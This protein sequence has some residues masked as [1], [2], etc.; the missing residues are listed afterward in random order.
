MNERWPTRATARLIT[1]AGGSQRPVGYFI[2]CRSCA[3]EIHRE[4][5]STHVGQFLAR[6]SWVNTSTAN[7]RAICPDCAI[8]LAGACVH[9]PNDSIAPVVVGQVT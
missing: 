7:V 2:R 6:H 5:T 9:E 1:V 3:A 4:D 8:A